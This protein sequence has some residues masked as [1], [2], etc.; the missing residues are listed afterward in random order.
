M[1]RVEEKAKQLPHEYVELERG[2]TIIFKV[3][4]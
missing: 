3:S 1:E 2:N 4:I